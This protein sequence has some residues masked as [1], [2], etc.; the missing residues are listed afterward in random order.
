[1]ISDEG[2]SFIHLN[3]PTKI[4]IRWSQMKHNPPSA[5]AIGLES[6][7]LDWSF[8]S[9]HKKLVSIAYAMALIPKKHMSK[10]HLPRNV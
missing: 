6:C 9:F 5:E 2:E 10:G 4:L 7:E 8:H 1:M 3:P